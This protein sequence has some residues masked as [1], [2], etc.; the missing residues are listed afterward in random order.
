MEIEPK[1]FLKKIYFFKFAFSPYAIFKI[2]VK[3]A[4]N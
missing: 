4:K 3:N 2:F 1:F